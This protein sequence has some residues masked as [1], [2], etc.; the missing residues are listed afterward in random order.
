MTRET[1]PKSLLDHAHAT[2][3][4]AHVL[5]TV[6]AVVR[7]VLG[8]DD[9]EHEDVVQATLEQLLTFSS[10]KAARDHDFA[11]QWASVVARNVAV[12][13]LR[14]RLRERR[15]LSRAD[16]TAATQRPSY[17]DPERIASARETLARFSESLD[18]LRETNAEVLFMHD[19]LGHSL[20]EIADALEMSVAAAQSR[21]V[22]GRRQITMDGISS[23]GAGKRAGLSPERSGDRAPRDIDESSPDVDEQLE[24]SMDEP[25]DEERH[26]EEE[27]EQ[28]EL[29]SRTGGV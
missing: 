9:V 1:D 23:G 10:Q 28:A 7:R 8:R 5:A 4:L 6:R 17:L 14:A 25:Q 18:R 12:D 16:D 27:E 13:A 24:G 22:R 29:G 2:E 3:V 26:E 15:V 11:R 20:A 21:L 19:V